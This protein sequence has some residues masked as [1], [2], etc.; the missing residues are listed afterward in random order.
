MMNARHARE[1]ATATAL[2]IGALA[3]A[4]LL[5]GCSTQYNGA[6]GG[7]KKDEPRIMTK[8]AQAQLAAAKAAEAEEA[9]KKDAWAHGPRASRDIATGMPTSATAPTPSSAP[10]AAA[11]APTSPQ[12]IEFSSP[13]ELSQGSDGAAAPIASSQRDRVRGMTLFGSVPDPQPKRTGAA[14]ADN[15]SQVT[16]TTEGAD[17]DP[18]IDPAGAWIVYASTQHRQTSDLYIKRV[19]GTAVTQLTDD[20]ANDVMP[21]VSPDGK[22]VAFAS[23]RSGTWNIYVVDINGGQPVQITSEPTHNLHPSFSR[24][25]RQIVYCTYGAQSGQWE[26]VVVDIERPAVK[27]YIGTGLNPTWSPVADKILFQRARERGTRWFSVWTLDL[28]NGEGLRPTEIAASSN[29]AVIT[30]RWSPDGKHVVFSTVVDPAADQNNRPAQADVWI[31]AAD[32]SGRVNLTRS[33]NITNLQPIW[34]RDGTIYFVS[35]RSKNSVENVYALRPDR[36]IQNVVQ[37]AAGGTWR[38]PVTPAQA[39]APTAA[40]SPAPQQNAAVMVE[41]PTEP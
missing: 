18:A 20:P 11:P 29:A 31:A 17:F 34:S 19:N 26:L 15:I 36:A 3:M 21:A 9:K 7:P 24:D 35:N 27:R 41:P 2:L 25:G 37:A 40:P 23:D 33:T 5:P 14:A 16:Y 38:D 39:A 4:T 22:R 8:E 32:G 30:P 12:R 13:G 10:V 6:M 1:I 28:E